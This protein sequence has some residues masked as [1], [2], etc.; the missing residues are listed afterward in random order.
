MR[1]SLPVLTSF[2]LSLTACAADGA[3]IAGELVVLEAGAA[4]P[5]AVGTACHFHLRPA[6]RSG[7][8]CQLLVTCPEPDADLFGGR[9]IG[10]YAVC[11]TSAHAFVRAEDES[12]LDGDPAILLDLPAASLSWRGAREGEMATLRVVSTEEAA[13]PEDADE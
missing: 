12:A 11:E 8:N 9:R 10:G 2:L 13:W 4:S 5:I 7:V 3:P 6:W 1:R